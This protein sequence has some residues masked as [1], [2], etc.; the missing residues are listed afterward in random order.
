MTV[1]ASDDALLDLGL[2]H[3]DRRG[4]AHQRADMASFPASYVVELHDE[5]IA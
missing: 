2:D 1:C 5:R 3:D 4:L